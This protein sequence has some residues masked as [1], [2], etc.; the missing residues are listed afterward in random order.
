[1][2]SLRQIIREIVK[3]DVG[4][5]LSGQIEKQKQRT[6]RKSVYDTKSVSMNGTELILYKKV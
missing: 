5:D 6:L 2:D 4:N 1:M 3:Y